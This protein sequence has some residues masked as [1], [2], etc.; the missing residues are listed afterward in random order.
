MAREQRPGQGGDDTSGNQGEGNRGADGRY[1][2]K[3][4]EFAESGRVEPAAED[5]RREVEEEEGDTTSD[6]ARDAGVEDEMSELKRHR[7]AL[8]E[9]LGGEPASGRRGRS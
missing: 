1:R 5:A 7:R 2:E 9:D 3:A 8:R 6:A 4:R